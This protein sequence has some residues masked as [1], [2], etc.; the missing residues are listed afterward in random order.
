MKTSAF[1]LLEAVIYLAVISL[2][3]S[4]LVIFAVNIIN[5]RAKVDLQ[6]EVESAAAL[7]EEVI[8][9]Q[10]RQAGTID[11]A[12]SRLEVATGVLALAP[13][14]TTGQA[15]TTIYLDNQSGQIRLAVGQTAPLDVTPAKLLVDNLNFHLSGRLLTVNLRLTGRSSSAFAPYFSYDRS[16][17]FS[18]MVKRFCVGQTTVLCP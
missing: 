16:Y 10:V 15:A 4:A 7:S 12:A 6:A 13:A 5:L 9:R 8:G 11:L 14:T 2:T 1:T 3:L 17:Q 18:V